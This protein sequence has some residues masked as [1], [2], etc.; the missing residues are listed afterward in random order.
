M[1]FFYNVSS[2]KKETISIFYSSPKIFSC[3]I[4]LNITKIA[5]LF[6]FLV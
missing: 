4:R 6:N 5:S 1:A 2:I 3:K